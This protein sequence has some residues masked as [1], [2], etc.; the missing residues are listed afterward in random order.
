RLHNIDEWRNPN[1]V[2]VVCDDRGR[3]LYF[4][5]API[6]WKRA[7]DPARPGFPDSLAFRH[8]GLYAFRVGALTRFAALPPHPLEQCEALDQLRALA[9]GMKIRVGITDQPAPR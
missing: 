4:S 9:H 3:A 7:Q 2:K 8:I 5:R 1:I 6:P